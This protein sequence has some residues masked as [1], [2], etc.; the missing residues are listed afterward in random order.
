MADD[1]PPDKPNTERKLAMAALL[2]LLTFAAFIALDWAINVRGA[3]E[4]AGA[5]EAPALVPALQPAPLGPPVF[6][7]GYELPEPLHYHRGH[8][9]ARVLSPDTVAVG[10]DDFARRLVGRVKALELPAVGAW[11][12]QGAA[13]AHAGADGRQAALVAPVD[14]KVVEV[15]AD[16][17]RRPSLAV[18]DPYGHGWLYKVR[19]PNLAEN[20]RNLLSGR[21]AQRW[22]EDAR[23]QLDL[24]L[25]ALSGSVLADGGAPA[26]DYAQHLDDA[27]WRRLVDTFLLAGQG[28]S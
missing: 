22:T 12:R 13:A 8:V 11:L 6:V 14:G 1:P 10:L 15:N 19:S 24:R 23:E 21:L 2:A 5:E 28:E 9:W 16:L 7:A 3:K 25:M 4:A 18:E 26:R 20:L 17:A 27:E